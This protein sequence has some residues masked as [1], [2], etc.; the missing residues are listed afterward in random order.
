MKKIEHIEWQEVL[1]IVLIL[2]MAF[3]MFYDA[4]RGPKLKKF[5]LQSIEM[6]VKVCEDKIM[7]LERKSEKSKE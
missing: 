2:M 4:I 7:V 3:L 6:R 1:L 5:E